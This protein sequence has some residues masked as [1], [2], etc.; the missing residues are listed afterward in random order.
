MKTISGDVMQ[1]ADGLA[2]TSRK[3]V[4]WLKRLES[5]SLSQEQ[6]NRGRFNSLADACKSDAH[7]YRST[8]GDIQKAI[9]AYEAA[10]TR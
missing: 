10:K 4:A 3:V 5:Q 6:A 9:D 2:K 1:A 8:A 7:N